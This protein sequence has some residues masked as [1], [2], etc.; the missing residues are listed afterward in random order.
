MAPPP[1]SLLRDLLAADGFKNRRKAPDNSLAAPRT[2]SMPLQHRRPSKP[3]RSQSDVLSRSR[4]RERNA[5]SNDGNRD[6]GDLT[7][8]RRSSASLTS[9]R[10][11]NNKDNSSGA[12]RGSTAIPSLDKSAL[13]ALISLVVGAVKRFVKDEAFRASLR[14]G[15]TSCLGESNHRAV[16]DLRVLVQTVERAA[17]EGFD[18]LDL[19]RASLKLH[20][21]ASL[22]PK[23]ADEVTAAGFPYQRL[24][25][26][27][28]L[29]MSVISKLQKK[30][31]SSAV[32]VLEVFCLAPHE[33]RTALLPALWD[34]L[35]RSGLSHL[36][37]W[38]D[39]ESA[40]ASSD[41]RVKEVEKMFI[42][43]LDDGTRA[44]ACYYRDWLLGRT[45]AMVLPAVPAPPST[46]LVS[47]LRCS[48]STSYDIGSDVAFSSGSMSPAKFAFD[49]TLRQP[50]EVEEE[51]EVMDE[52]T[53]DAESVFHECD[54]AEASSYTPTLQVDENE[55][56]PNKLAKETF[57]PQIEDDRSKESDVST[58]YQLITD[59][60]AVGLLTLEFLSEE[61]LQSD[62][63]GNQVSIFATTPSD[64]LCPL[65]RQIFN[66]SVT[67]ETGHTFERHAIVQWF[68]KGMRT[69]PVTGQELESLSIPDTNRVLK[70][71]VE[72]WKFEHCKNLISGST[73]PD[74]KLTIT[75]IDKVLNSGYDMS[76]NFEKA[77]HL[78]AIGGI[79]FLLHR[80]QEGREDEKA[81]AAEHLLLCI[82]AEGSCRN[83]VAIRLNSSSVVQLLHSE[84]ISARS[85]AVCLLIE[86]LCLRRR[87]MVELF[88]RGLRTE[89]TMET[90]NVLLEHL[91]GSPS[92]EQAL[93]AVLL[94]HFDCTLVEPHS[95]SIYREEA[96]KIIT[97]SLRSCL[98]E[99]NAVPNTRKALL[100]LGGIFSFSGDLL[101]EDWMLKQ[102]G[103]VA[104]SRAT[105]VNSDAVVQEKERSE[106]EAWLR[107]VTVVLLGNGR[108][109]FLE[110][111]SKCL[112]SPN[113]DLVAACLTTA[114]WL[115]R[116][117]AS[118]DATDMQ[119]AAFSALIPRIKQ[120]LASA[121]LQTR[122]RVLASVTL[123]NFSKI[124]DCRALLMLLADGLSEHLAELAELSWTAGQLS[125]ELHEWR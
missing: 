47:A 87:E 4:L 8:T 71:L 105:L 3:A 28:H 123:L 35:F 60:S 114:G 43:V 42:D 24:A 51:E 53:A 76:E 98:S 81:R 125:A 66:R 67:I 49:E 5:D 38:R 7:A 31:H 96:A 84:V 44:L 100:M 86:L 18:P 108:R 32:H 112:S 27:A 83:Y 64:F 80:F 104:D 58:S 65:T 119:L 20:A 73:G 117:L 57:E 90:M 69:C 95:N 12:A 48:T 63:D 37:T 9:A 10:S 91:R 106:N 99:D 23:E 78:M 82:R 21:M 45:E 79:D 75:V 33:A 77:R 121:H 103:F 70:R 46:V 101:A 36:R 16:L 102:A 54:G 111:L 120:C 55:L 68:E 74:E 110:A 107:N 116:S 29:Y 59:I 17:R 118:V 6:A 97:H 26:C 13:T 61:P 52:K 25:A 88:L 56:M 15:C 113:P 94:L 22:D 122:H 41:T 85:T 11:Y 34:R 14:G 39:R 89:L 72:N 93:V 30:D 1:S 109:S 92:E 124:P 19:K 62:T 115:S 2:V 40:A 50:E